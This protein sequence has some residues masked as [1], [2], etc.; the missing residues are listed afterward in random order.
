MS[1]KFN[2]M[3]AL[4]S[5]IC[6]AGHGGEWWPSRRSIG[7]NDDDCPPS[8]RSIGLN[9]EYPSTRSIGLN[10]EEDYEYGETKK[11][12]DENPIYLPNLK[13]ENIS[14]Q[15]TVESIL[16]EELELRFIDARSLATTAKLKLEIKGYP[17]NV[18]KVQ[19]A[20]KSMALFFDLPLDDQLS[21]RQ[22]KVVFDSVKDSMSMASKSISRLSA[23]NL[24]PKKEEMMKRRRSLF[25]GMGVNLPSLSGGVRRSGRSVASA[26]SS[27]QP[28]RS[29]ILVRAKKKSTASDYDSD[30]E[31]TNYGDDVS[32]LSS[33]DGSTMD[34]LTSVDG[35]VDDDDTVSNERVIHNHH[36]TMS[37][38][39]RVS[40]TELLS[41]RKSR[42]GRPRR[43][44]RRLF[45]NG[46]IEEGEEEEQKANAGEKPSSSK[47]KR[48]SWG[49]PQKQRGFRR[50][51]RELKKEDLS[52]SFVQADNEYLS[53]HFIEAIVGPSSQKFVKPF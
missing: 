21:M 11:E 3:D 38:C 31:G 20:N 16:M 41:S 51:S 17:S 45:S 4:S 24:R 19:L 18:Q 13:P 1:P 47:K 33:D 48:P 36:E 22:T 6:S 2:G 39:S 29:A 43:V 32:R 52:G 10:D 27:K 26:T 12:E 44:L 7:L 40:D 9:D 49:G 37:T 23:D 42:R 14:R 30:E 28:R 35:S 34:D 25:G 50:P 8:T 46:S 15:T 5:S 53:D